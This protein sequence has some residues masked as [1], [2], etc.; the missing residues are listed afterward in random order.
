MIEIDGSVGEGGGQVMRTSLTLSALLGEPVRLS[1]IRKGREK[2]GMMA[3][4]FTVVRALQQI[5]GAEI[6]GA[7]LGS[8]ELVFKPGKVCA[9]EYSFDIETAGSVVLVLQA[10]MPALMNAGSK[11]RISL[12]GGTHVL[13]CPNFDEFHETFLPAAHAMG[14]GFSAKIVEPGFFPK[15]GGKAEA[16]V[17]PSGPKPHD[18]VERE[19]ENELECIIRSSNLPLHVAE[20]EAA[21]VKKHFPGAA[22]RRFDARSKSTG[23]AV[24]LHSGFLAANA[25]GAPGKSAESVAKEACAKMKAEL[26]SGACVDMHLADQLLLYMALA[27]KG[28]LL[29]SEL[30][31]H[32]QTNMIIIEKF[33][34]K[35]FEAEGSM[36]SVTV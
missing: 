4:H 32:T 30:T 13:R 27:G 5:T 29:A 31:A 3:Q 6:E 22:V 8:T 12:T 35:T 19:R 1:N 16:E 18:F 17:S 10:A 7:K 33:L 2:P 14:C 15:G 26:D 23:N 20:R 25:L 36:I 24:T 21:E 11:S 9:G 28:S 34:G